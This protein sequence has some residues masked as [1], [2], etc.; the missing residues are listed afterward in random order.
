M[1]SRCR[2]SNFSL[3]E[4][5]IFIELLVKNYP[6]LHEDKGHSKSNNDIR[7][8]AWNDLTKD[9][10]V[11]LAEKNVYRTT[12]QLKTLYENIKHKFQARLPCTSFDQKS[13]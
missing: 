1:T 8:T 7:S 5:C 13:L 2:T 10:H 4:R 12:K 6:F 9:F 11:R 3:K